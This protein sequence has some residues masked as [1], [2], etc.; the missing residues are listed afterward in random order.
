M[1]GFSNDITGFAA[2]TIVEFLIQELVIKGV[3]DKEEVDRLLEAAANR[4]DRAANGE[5]EIIG[6]N[7]EAARLIRALSEGLQPLFA[8]A[9]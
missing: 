5:L 3:L 2:L 4:H 6:L 8:E 9:D 7:V 1:Q